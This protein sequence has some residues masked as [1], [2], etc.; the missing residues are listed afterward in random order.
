MKCKV[1]SSCSKGYFKSQPDKY[2]CIGVKEPF[3]IKDINHECTEYPEKN[4]ELNNKSTKLTAPCSVC[5]DGQVRINFI[6]A[7]NVTSRYA[8]YDL[9][10]LDKVNFCPKCGKR[11]IG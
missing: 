3:I 7:M 2:V 1:C 6:S 5:N 9:G 10:R 8:T 11:L 4:S